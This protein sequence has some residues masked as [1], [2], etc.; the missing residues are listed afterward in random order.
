MGGGFLGDDG[1]M[2]EEGRRQESG[3][4]FQPTE[5]WLMELKESLPLETVTRLLQHLVPVVDEIV[6]NKD[7]EG[8]GEMPPL[9]F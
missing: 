4:P 1:A 7:K 8:A 3:A 9:N 5:Q 6:A 2:D